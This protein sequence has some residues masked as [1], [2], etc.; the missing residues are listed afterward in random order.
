MYTKVNGCHELT[1]E[2]A[3]NRYDIEASVTGEYI[4]GII[5]NAL[6]GGIGY[7][8]CLDNTRPE[9]DNKPENMPTACYATQLILEGKTLYFTDAESDED[10]EDTWELNLYKLL[11]GIGQAMTKGIFPT[12][13]DLDA[14]DADCVIQY[15]LFGKIIFS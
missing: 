10:E 15:A 3:G 8:A 1:Q 9:W 4:E 7:W 11:S 5:V 12:S 6:E 13:L 2:W 14:D